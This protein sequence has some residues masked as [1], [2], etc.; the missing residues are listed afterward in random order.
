M[1]GIWMAV[2]V[3]YSKAIRKD[4]PDIVTKLLFSSAE[5]LKQ[6]LFPSTNIPLSVR[7][8]F[9]LAIFYPESGSEISMT[10]GRFLALIPKMFWRWL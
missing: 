10:H 6:K 5:N 2:T 1:S 7:K 3:P 8:R 4:A 9:T